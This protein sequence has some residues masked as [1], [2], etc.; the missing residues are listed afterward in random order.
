MVPPVTFASERLLHRDRLAADHGFVDGAA[1]FGDDAVGGNLLAGTNAQL[2][3]DVDSAEFDVVFG[4]VR[5]DAARG[6]W[7]QSEQSGER[8]AGSAAGFQ[9]QHLAEQHQHGDDGGGFKVE[10][11]LAGHVSKRCGKELRDDDGRDTI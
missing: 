8:A 9:L 4:A 6:L 1:A 7:G 11:E 2:V 5:G 10:A 3:A